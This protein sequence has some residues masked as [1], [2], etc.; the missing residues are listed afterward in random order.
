MTSPTSSDPTSTDEEPSA[1]PHLS[2]EQD[3]PGDTPSASKPPWLI[4][5]SILI[6]GGVSV[7][8]WFWWRSQN[9]DPT[10]SPPS[11]AQGV[12][13]EVQTL[14]PTPIEESEEFVGSLDAPRSVEVKP[15]VEGRIREILVQEGEFIPRGASL[16]QLSPE[17]QQAD[18][19]SLRQGINIARATRA[20]AV[21][22]IAALE[23]ERGS[24]LADLALQETSYQR[25][26]NLV[27]EG[28]LAQAQ[29]DEITRDRD[30]ANAQL[31]AID[32]NIEAGQARLAEAEAQLQQAQ[33]NASR[34]E[35]EL[36]DT[37]I[38]TPFAGTV[39]NIPAKVGDYVEQGDTLTSITQNQTLEVELNIPIEKASQLRL[40]QTVEGRD[41]QGN[42][43][44]TGSLSFIAPQ[45]DRTSQS[46]L[47]KAE[48]A[49]PEGRLRD[50]QLIRARII[51]D[52][53]SGII[54]PT[55]AINRL[56]GQTF[57]FVAEEGEAVSLIARQKLVQLG[58][59]QGNNYRVLEGLEAGERLIT[60]GILNL[61]D[62]TPVT[63]T[64]NQ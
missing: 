5:L 62:G 47:V 30:R 40:G 7:G 48:F 33:A 42:L 6:I 49:N 29:L 41:N 9:S 14:S 61:A 23:A 22:E 12:S 63:V 2:P 43:L 55:T 27:Q 1:D 16:I 39:G 20:R 36:Q 26:S 3:P 13:V 52:T 38:I 58:E 51:W 60:S 45:V 25:I 21:S 44:A 15:E 8:A 35:A 4:L 64:S 28:A 54:V 53:L 11:Q 17:K 59:I 50:G 24:V 37:T 10:P 56:G 31:N 34:A 19:T 18:V 32:R 57:V 46:L